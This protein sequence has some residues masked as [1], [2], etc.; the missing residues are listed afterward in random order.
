MCLSGKRCEQLFIVRERE[1]D[2]QEGAI[3]SERRQTEPIILRLD[4]LATP[5]QRDW[6]RFAGVET[7]RFREHAELLVQE[8]E[9]AWQAKPAT[10]LQEY[11]LRLRGHWREGLSQR[12]AFYLVGTIADHERGNELQAG[13]LPAWERL[14]ELEPRLRDLYD[15]ACAPSAGKRPFCRLVGLGAEQPGLLTSVEAYRVGYETLFAALPE[16]DE[17]CSCEGP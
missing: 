2:G 3:M 1:S 14:V 9:D 11:F 17:N 4:S 7:P 8:I 6:L 12:Q 15:E 13:V 16:C 10:G 5:E